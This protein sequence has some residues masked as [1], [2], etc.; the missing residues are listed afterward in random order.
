MLVASAGVLPYHT[1]NAS[2]SKDYKKS[3]KTMLLHSVY[4]WLKNGVSEV[5]R[6]E[7]EK[8]MRDLVAD[9]KEVHK[10]EIGKP[11]G[12]PDRSVVDHSFHYSLCVWFTS[13]E[14]HDIYQEHPAHKRFV[15]DFSSLWTEVRVYDSQIL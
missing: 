9:V 6:K 13:I 3:D 10:S 12:T 5:E 2:S 15:D 14:N 11:A 4:F 8:G 1:L 7:F